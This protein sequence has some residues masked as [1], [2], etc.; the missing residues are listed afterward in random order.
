MATSE[1]PAPAGPGE[2]SGTPRTLETAWFI[3]GD[4]HT[5]AGKTIEVRRRRTLRYRLARVYHL[6]IVWLLTAIGR[7]ADRLPPPE[8]ERVPN[9]LEDFPHDDYFVGF[10]DAMIAMCGHA[11]RTL[12]LMLMGDCFD[13]LAVT[14]NGK[15][16]EKRTEKNGAKKM[17][18]IIMGHPAFFDAL[19]SFLR[20]TNAEL[21]IFTGNHDSFL[22]WPLVR[23][24]VVRRLA[25]NDPVIAAKIRFV[26]YAERYRLIEDEVY[27]D[28]AMNAEPHTALDPDK[29]FITER[30]G[31]KLA[32]PE[33]N[34]PLGNLM[35]EEIVH[36]IKQENQNVGT[37]EEEPHAWNE[38][39]RF[40]RYG[41]AIRSGVTLAAFYWRR[42]AEGFSTI[43]KVVASTM[44]KPKPSKEPVIAYAEK[45]LRDHK[46]NVRAV[47]V[48]H[49]HRPCRL[50]PEEGGTIVNVGSPTRRRRLVWPEAADSPDKRGF[51]GEGWRGLLHHLYSSKTPFGHT[52]SLLVL[53]VAIASLLVAALLTSFG[54]AWTLTIILSKLFILVTLGFLCLKMLVRFFM[55]KPAVEEYVLFTCGLKRRYSDG[56]LLADLMRYDIAE[57]TIRE[58]V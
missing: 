21:V 1:R 19:A 10:V 44:P 20:L 52:A 36:S 14:I 55:I 41:W 5:G 38:A 7:K 17:M 56:T 23:K 39:W 57:K 27:F 22:N 24:L 6:C 34:E 15:F 42:S 9:K 46:G 30:H 33:L 43:I 48:A 3:F 53:Y 25:K 4:I 32:E 12:G 2:E 29:P 37:L 26:G 54:T 18:K 49:S 47:F 13:A 31:K 40:G 35:T 8:T 50:T 58:H 51:F 11:A 28:H 45:A 16:G